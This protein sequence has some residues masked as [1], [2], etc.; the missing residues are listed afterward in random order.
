[1]RGGARGEGGGEGVGVVGAVAE[2]AVGRERGGEGAEG[3]CCSV[4]ALLMTTLLA[5]MTCFFIWC[6]ST[7]S[8]GEHLYAS[9][10][11]GEQAVG[12]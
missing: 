12:G 1:M 5:S 10:T 2:G 3:A 11:C 6:E 8:T 7:P 9:A 4:V